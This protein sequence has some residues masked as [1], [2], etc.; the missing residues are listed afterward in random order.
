MATHPREL[1]STVCS[2]ARTMELIGQPWTMLVLRDLFNG[3]RRFD[4]LAE[5][6]GI[7]RNV[8]TR[9]LATL[10]DAGLVTRRSYREPGQRARHEY[11]LTQAGHALRP[12]LI[13]VMAYGDEHL[14]GPEGPPVQLEHADCGAPV[15]VRL[16]CAEGHRLDPTARLRVRPGPGAR[17]RWSEPVSD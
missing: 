3:V 9:R 17:F 11:R 1:D 10:V 7:A 2:I 15:T 16:E 5:H 14:A 13:A 4:E 6:L 12:V 8:L